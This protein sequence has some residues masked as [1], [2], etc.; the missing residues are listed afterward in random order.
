MMKL[1]NH[2]TGETLVENLEVARSLW[3]RTKGLLGR[4]SLPA[5]HGLWIL[6]CNSVHTFFM[7]FPIDLIFLNRDMEVAKTYKSV[8][9]GRVV[10]PV[11]SASSVVEL[12]GGFLERHPV[13]VGEKLN[14]DSAV[15]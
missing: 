1:R 10:W 6:R 14:V 12:S 4:A 3:T 11:L 2:R 5:G 15:S 13:Q 8:R 9:P 7:K